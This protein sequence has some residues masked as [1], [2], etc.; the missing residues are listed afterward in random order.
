MLKYLQLYHWNWTRANALMNFYGTYEILAGVPALLGFPRGNRNSI[1]CGETVEISHFISNSMVW[2]YTTQSFIQIGLTIAG[3]QK[4]QNYG[5]P[6]LKK[7]KPAIRRP[8]VWA[9]TTQSFVTI[10]VTVADYSIEKHM[11]TLNKKI[12]ALCK[13]PWHQDLPHK[14]SSKSVQP[15]WNA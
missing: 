4:S 15:F 2:L 10:G 13:V 12:R 11:A 8:M 5:N 3:L 7:I 6:E 9:S 14:V 1:R